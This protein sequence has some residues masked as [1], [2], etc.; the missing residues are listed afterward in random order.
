MVHI[1]QLNRD[2]LITILLILAGILL[3]VT[4]FGAGAF[5]KG[6]SNWHN[7][8]LFPALKAWSTTGNWK[9]APRLLQDRRQTG[10][11]ALLT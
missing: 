4:L 2:T 10:S 11:Y 3:A 9:P 1:R 7:S 8:G 6:K 5:W